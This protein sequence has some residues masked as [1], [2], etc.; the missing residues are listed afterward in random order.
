MGSLYFLQSSRKRCHLPGC[1]GPEDFVYQIGVLQVAGPYAKQSFI[2]TVH[3]SCTIG[4]VHGLH[5][6]DGHKLLVR[7]HSLCHDDPVNSTFS[8]S[9]AGNT[10]SPS[11]APQQQPL[12]SSS[13]NGT[14]QHELRNS[15]SPTAAP[16][17]QLPNSS[18]A[19][20]LTYE[21]VK[22]NILYLFI[23]TSQNPNG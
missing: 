7:G 23:W 4:P 3:Q 15:S 18:P 12:N 11:A 21:G 14:P 8:L 5:L 17:Q 2:C 19:S 13:R 10:S 22:A 9:F 1:D 16:Q 20:G 6:K